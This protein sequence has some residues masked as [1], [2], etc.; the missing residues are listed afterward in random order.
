MVAP[1]LYPKPGIKSN[2]A[3]VGC[4]KYVICKKLLITDS[5]F[6]STVTGKTYFI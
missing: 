5:K 2:H 3:I 6:R 4:N 1:S